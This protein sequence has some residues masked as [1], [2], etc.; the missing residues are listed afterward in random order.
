MYL[1][2]IKSTWDKPTA[3]ILLR[4]GTQQGCTRLPHLFNTV[5]E[6]LARAVRQEKERENAYKSEKK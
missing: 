4:S 6:I 1:N 5:L 2:S 3:D